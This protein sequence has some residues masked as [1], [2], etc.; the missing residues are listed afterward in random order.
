[1]TIGKREVEAGGVRLRKI[2]RTE[3]VQHPWNSI[4]KRS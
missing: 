4:V 1:M 2:I 3:V